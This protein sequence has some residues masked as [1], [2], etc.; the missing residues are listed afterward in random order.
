M[1][2]YFCLEQTARHRGER[3]G[4]GTRPPGGDPRASDGDEE[5]EADGDGR[6]CVRALYSPPRLRNG[7]FAHASVCFSLS[8][9]SVPG[10]LVSGEM[11]EMALHLHVCVCSR[12]C[13]LTCAPRAGRS[14]ARNGWQETFPR[15]SL[16]RPRVSLQARGT[17]LGCTRHEVRLSNRPRWWN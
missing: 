6:R 2:D 4:L 17:R 11:A 10:A 3:H 7:S 15:T 16:S 8:K 1:V 9:H 5:E 12:A 13:A 14:R